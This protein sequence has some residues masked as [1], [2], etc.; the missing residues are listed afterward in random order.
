MNLSTQF[1][2][3]KLA[4]PIVVSSS[5]ITSKYENIRKC[6]DA[7]AGAIVLKSLFEE[8]LLADTNKLNEQE[9][10]YFWYPE[11]VEQINTYAKEHGISE[12]LNLITE[13]KQQNEVPIIASINCRTSREWPEFSKKIQDAGADALELNIDVNPFDP[14][15]KSNE[16][17]DT[18]IEIINEV[19]KYVTLPIS[20]KIGSRFTN[21]HRITSRIQDTGANGLVLFNRYYYPDIDIEK[22]M[23]AKEGP[24][25]GP[26]EMYRSLR[27]VVLMS[28]ALKIDIAASTGI[29]EYQSIIKQLLA[30]AKVV[31]ITTTLYMHGI[32]YITELLHSVREWMLRCGYSSVDEFRGLIHNDPENIVAFER[33]QFIKKTA[34]LF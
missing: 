23:L 9:S 34:H 8:Q 3:L 5:G 25:S 10:M 26:K 33:L 18:Y 1:L 11:A 21:L 4:N 12:Y 13:C 32:D 30:G 7:G 29:H 17:E 24:L 20:V 2:G 19:K 31:Y 6:I 15:I 27:W 16:I 28:K 14:I 22:R